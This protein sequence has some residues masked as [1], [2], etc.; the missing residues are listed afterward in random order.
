M[1]GDQ[2]VLIV[3]PVTWDRFPDREGPGGT[4]S[5]AARTA[6]AMGLRAH[7]LTVAAPGADLSA[8]EGHEVCV[9]PSARTMVFEHVYDGAVRTLRV[10][11]T[12]DRV[13]RPSD[14]PAHWPAPDVM[15]VAPLIDGELHDQDAVLGHHADQQH[16]PDLAVGV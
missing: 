11:A 1:P 9:V 12:P 8:L 13:L 16:Q 7:V 2:A 5:Y 3:G 10:T 6:A 4:V 15:I 14:L